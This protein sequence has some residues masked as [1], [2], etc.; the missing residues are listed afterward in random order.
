MSIT[1]I[2]AAFGGGLFAAAIGGVPSFIFTGLTVVAAILGGAAGA[3]AIDVVAFGPWFVPCSAFAGAVAASA[4]AKRVGILE[5]GMDIITPLAGLKSPMTL[6]VGGIFGVIGIVIEYLVS[7]LGMLS[8]TDTVACT[9][10][11]SAIITRI[12]FTQS[13]LTGKTPDGVQ[14]EWVP[15]GKDLSFSIMFGLG[16]G[17]LAGGIVAILGGMAYDTTGNLM[18]ENAA[19]IFTNMGS[20]AFG[21]AAIGLIF[22]CM[23]KPFFGCHHI[24]YP[25]AATAV[26]IYSATLN[27]LAAIVGAAVM[28]IFTTWFGEVMG[29]TFNSYADSHIDPPACTIFVAQ[30]INASILP[31]IF[32]SV[33]A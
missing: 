24:I 19:W 15:K 16:S 2:L 6:L 29:R 11:I 21:I 33:L 5:D 25:A 1:T 27:S 3:P 14:R 30:I 18:N 10:V 8:W 31:M 26:V 22:S 13:G 28:G 17:I 23:G 20:F 7:G 4:Y 9:V 32:V 12:V